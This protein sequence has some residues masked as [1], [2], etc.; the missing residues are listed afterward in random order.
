LG[1]IAE[2]LNCGP[3]SGSAKVAKLSISGIG[4]RSHTKVA[5]R[6]FRCLSE[7][8]INVEMIN[9]SEVRVNVVVDGS[10]GAKALAALEQAFADARQ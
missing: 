3:I 10:Q 6:T 7:A 9:T 8:G 4:M 2:R 1:Q 5:I